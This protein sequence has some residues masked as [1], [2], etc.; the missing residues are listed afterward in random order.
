MLKLI[1][2]NMTNLNTLETTLKAIEEAINT[3]KNG[4][5]TE[6][7]LAHFVENTKELYE[8]AVVLRY[9]AYEEKVFG[10][11]KPIVE[12]VIEPVLEETIIPT[13]TQ[14]EPE[15]PA[16]EFG[17]FD[18]METSSEEEIS[19]ELVEEEVSEEQEMLNEEEENFEQATI[20]EA[21]DE[22][23]IPVSE[24]P[25]ELELEITP[26]SHPFE[27]DNTLFNSSEIIDETSEILENEMEEE[28]LDE[29]EEQSE[30]FVSSEEY[31]TEPYLK[32]TEITSENNN[33]NSIHSSLLQISSKVASP[34]GMMKLDTLIGSFGLNERLQYINELFEGS[35]EGFSEAIKAIDH[36]GDFN[37][38]IEK[39][40]GFANQHHW[41]LES[42]TVEDFIAKV[43]RRHA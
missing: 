30:A 3:L 1:R 38:A 21:A 6:E 9:K 24:L 32:V 19:E 26:S 2:K 14:L 42:E 31:S 20:F 4:Q 8:K 15:T 13:A 17:L 43:K 34:A 27:A 39:I 16:F 36:S 33:I 25:V 7:E 40:A 5:L 29:E 10:H 18:T 22:V 35:S 28:D 37:Q 12:A 23:E 41:D 11:P